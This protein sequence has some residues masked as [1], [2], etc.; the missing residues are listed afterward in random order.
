MESTKGRVATLTAILYLVGSL[1]LLIAVFRL[2]GL[3]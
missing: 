3:Y 2:F 1:V